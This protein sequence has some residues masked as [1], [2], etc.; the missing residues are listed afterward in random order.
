MFLIIIIEVLIKCVI[1]KTC[2][3]DVGVDEYDG[4]RS[5]LKEG[6]RVE[7]DSTGSGYNSRICGASETEW[8]SGDFLH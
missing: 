1:S 6:M 3:E 8:R 2:K 7:L 5:Y 4:S